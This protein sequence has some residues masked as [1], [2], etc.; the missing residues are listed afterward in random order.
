MLAKFFLAVMKVHWNKG[1]GRM[2][3]GNKMMGRFSNGVAN[4]VEVLEFGF[5]LDLLVYTCI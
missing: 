5:K 3:L 2:L 1:G 4:Q